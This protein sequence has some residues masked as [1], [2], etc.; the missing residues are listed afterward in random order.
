VKEAN[1]QS[2]NEETLHGA[3]TKYLTAIIVTQEI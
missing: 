2:K 1:F 3:K